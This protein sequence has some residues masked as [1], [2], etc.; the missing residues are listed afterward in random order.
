MTL[1]NFNVGNCRYHRALCIYLP[2]ANPKHL[3][4]HDALQARN[5]TRKGFLERKS[6]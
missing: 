1:L 2:F 5:Y 3:S 4:T 6:Y